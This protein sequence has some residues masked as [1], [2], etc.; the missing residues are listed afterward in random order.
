MTNE[1]EVQPLPIEHRRKTFGL[2]LVLF[3][4]SLP[5][6]FLY[7]TGYR[8]EFGERTNIISTGGMYIA[9]ERTGA[10]IYIDDELV[11][12]TRAF[13]RAFYAQNIDPGTH[14]VHVQKVDHHTW[15]K[16]LP[17]SPHLVTEAQSFNLPL[18]PQIRVI[19]EWQT[20]TGTA[21][22]KSFSLNASTTN[23]IYATSSFATTTL[24]HNTEYLTL[25]KLFATTTIDES[26][27]EEVGGLLFDEFITLVNEATTTATSSEVTATT[28]KNGGDVILY[29]V[30]NDIYAR[31][32]GTRE[33]MPYYY[34]A[35]DF[36]RYST[37]TEALGFVD[38]IG[39]LAANTAELIHP[40]QTVSEDLVCQPEIKIDRLNQR[41]TTFDF[42]PGSTDF[43]VMTLEGGVYVVEVDDRAWQNVQ[44]LLLGENLITHV[45]NGQIY[46]YDGVL[47][48]QVFWEV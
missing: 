4:L 23:D 35:E 32:V 13:R 45:E 46:V 30:E 8:F 24:V 31:W 14:R 37:T 38:D 3:I 17:V 36:P 42:L 41:V 5:F 22:V 43:V 2:L 28:T 20:A 34:C 33:S 15:V 7:A 39:E 10:E 6:L 47:I 27:K 19:S 48:Y 40:V 11:R 18:V 44:P 16:E 12:E 9:A 26:E 29:E 25:L 1:P 21:I